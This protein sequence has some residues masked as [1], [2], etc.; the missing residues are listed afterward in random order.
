MIW[1]TLD[2]TPIIDRALRRRAAWDARAN[3]LEE[4][5]LASCN[6]ED[7]DYEAVEWLERLAQLV[8]PHLGADEDVDRWCEREEQRLLQLAR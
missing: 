1:K 8:G 2:L 6:D 3:Y 5:Y 7:I 4:L